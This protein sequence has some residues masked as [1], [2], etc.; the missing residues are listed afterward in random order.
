MVIYFVFLLLASIVGALFIN[1]FWNITRG[2][3]ETNEKGEKY[4]IG[5][6][7]CWYHKF[8]ENN[9][10]ETRYY[11]NKE[12]ERVFYAFFY[13][14]FS[15]KKEDVIEFSGDCVFVNTV[16]SKK[17]LIM[18]NMMAEKENVYFITHLIDEGITKVAAI[19][20]VKKYKIPYWISDPLGLCIT[21][22]A[23]V[24]GLISYF[25][26]FA[27]AVDIEQ[28][29]S[30]AKIAE[31]VSMEVDKVIIFS[32]FTIKTHLLT[33]ILYCVSLAFWNEL[34]NHLNNKLKK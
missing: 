32:S 12:L 27:V 30:V 11:E 34:F 31:G 20:E 21:C 23:S 7:F 5:K 29:N 2:R 4:W 1:G 28:A 24:F 25:M 16:L 15:L 17:D 9:Y 13:P 3:W 6:I 8:L 10:L 26:F 19:K 22:M 33:I 18:L 14:F